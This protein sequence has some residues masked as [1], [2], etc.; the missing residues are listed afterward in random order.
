MGMVGLTDNIVG[1]IKQSMYRWKTNLYADGKLLGSVPIRRGMFQG[2]SFSSLLIVI[3]LLPLAHILTEIGIVYQLEKNG[4]KFNHLF[5][6][7]D[8]KLYGKNDKE[9]ILSKVNKQVFLVGNFNINLLNY[10]GPQPINEFLDSLASNS[11]IQYILQPTRITSHSKTVMDNIL[12][13]IIS[14]EVISGN[15]IIYLNFC[16]LVM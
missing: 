16:L 15:M 3:T 4:A 6:M 1:L 5:L 7:D 10:S 12:S 13:D 14:H 9:N 11:F 2:D 8:L